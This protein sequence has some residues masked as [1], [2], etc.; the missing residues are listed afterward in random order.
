MNKI[1][2]MAELVDAPDLK[3]GSN[4][5][6]ASSTLA[7]GTNEIGE[8]YIASVAEIGCNEEGLSKFHIIE[9][10]AESI[11]AARVEVASIILSKVTYKVPKEG[12]LWEVSIRRKEDEHL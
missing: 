5:R 9:I 4:N 3:F 7:V 8:T 2:H 11:D 10:E 1:A 6:S 12:I